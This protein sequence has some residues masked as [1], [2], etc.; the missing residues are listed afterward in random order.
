MA[1]SAKVVGSAQRRRSG[2]VLQHGSM[3]LARSAITPELPGPAELPPVADA[4]YWSAR[5]NE[6]IPAILSLKP[7]T[8]PLPEALLE[9]ARLLE[10]TVYRND[11]WTRKR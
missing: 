5:L 6:R 4:R 11:R 10:Q 9:R 7:D 1:E 8:A 2:A 3:M